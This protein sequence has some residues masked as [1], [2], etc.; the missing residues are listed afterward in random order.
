M[1]REL[2]SSVIC[3][4]FEGV[5]ITELDLNFVRVLGSTLG[6]YLK[7]GNRDHGTWAWKRV[8]IFR[9]TWILTKT[10]TKSMENFHQINFMEKKNSLYGI[11]WN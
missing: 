8:H 11:C 5:R 6:L 3:T 7:H 9:K 1:E 2:A 4:H 10:W